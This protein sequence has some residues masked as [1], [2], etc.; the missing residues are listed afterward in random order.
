MAFI[1]KEQIKII[2]RHPRP[3]GYVEV[4]DKMGGHAHFVEKAKG[5]EVTLL[6]PEHA[7]SMFPD[8]VD[9]KERGQREQFIG[10]LQDVGE[11]VSKRPFSRFSARR[12]YSRFLKGN[13]K[14]ELKISDVAAP[15]YEDPQ[16]DPV[17]R[18]I[19]LGEIVSQRKFSGLT[20]VTVRRLQSMRAAGKVVCYEKSAFGTKDNQSPKILYPLWQVRGHA[21][22][23]EVEELI[24]NFGS[25]G[26]GLIRFMETYAPSL[27]AK[28]K[29]IYINGG[30]IG[31]N[32]VLRLA[33]RDGDHL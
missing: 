26:Y 27:N 21:I 5:K 4:R 16:E 1:A 6:V 7:K 18:E 19:K 20:G 8:C 11:R 24:E 12:P 33:Q 28:P 32:N 31:K 17:E 3:T 29:D 15:I 10:Q 22:S 2:K 25:N 9:V 30:V 14:D 23:E 13:Y